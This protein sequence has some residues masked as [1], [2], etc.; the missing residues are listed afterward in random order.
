MR[1]CLLGCK[2]RDSFILER[3]SAPRRLDPSRATSLNFQA[4]AASNPLHNDRG[5]GEESSSGAGILVDHIPRVR[6]LHAN[7]EDLQASHYE[8]YRVMLLIK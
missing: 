4:S 5:E 8:A 6:V 3:L 2:L 1:A 7:N